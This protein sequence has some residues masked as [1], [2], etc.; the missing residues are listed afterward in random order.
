VQVYLQ[1]YN[2]NGNWYTIASTENP[3]GTDVYSNPT[4]TNDY[5]VQTAYGYVC[6]RTYRG[7]GKGGQ[8]HLSGNTFYWSSGWPQFASGPNYNC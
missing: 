8:G 4:P 1:V 3:P 6:P 2:T 5:W 7:D